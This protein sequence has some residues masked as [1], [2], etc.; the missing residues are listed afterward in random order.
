[1]IAP[2]AGTVVIAAVAA[3][4]T[5]TA[6][7]GQQLASTDA[8]VHAQRLAAMA[9]CDS[10]LDATQRVGCRAQKSYDFDIARTAAAKQRIETAGKAI[11]EADQRIIEAE[12]L[13]RC[14][15]FLRGKRDS[16]TVF[17]RKITRENMC[18]YAREL[19]MRDGPG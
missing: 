13:Q 8:D 5:G 18:P 2:S 16:G 15:E 9:V 19:G 12:R 11:A 10:I 4:I 6:A 7:L 14:G 3:A 17:D 1:M